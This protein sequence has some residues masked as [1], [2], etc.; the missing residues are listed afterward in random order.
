MGLADSES[1]RYRILATNG[2]IGIPGPLNQWIC[3]SYRSDHDARMQAQLS[4]A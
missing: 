4:G 2:H 1:I 3:V